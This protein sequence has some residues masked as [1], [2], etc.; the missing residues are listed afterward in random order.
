MDPASPTA[1]KKTIILTLFMSSGSRLAEQTA[2]FEIKNVDV[3]RAGDHFEHETHQGYL[4]RIIHSL[5]DRPHGIAGNAHVFFEFITHRF[6][7]FVNQLFGNFTAFEIEA[8]LENGEVLEVI[9]HP[10]AKS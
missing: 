3:V 4:P 10:F 8:V 6:Q 9:L 7:R 1:R 2:A 5:D